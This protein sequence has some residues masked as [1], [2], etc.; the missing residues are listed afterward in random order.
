MSSMRSLVRG[1]L[2]LG[3]LG[4]ALLGQAAL[5]A[6]STPRINSPAHGTRFVDAQY[7]NLSFTFWRQRTRSITWRL[8]DN[9][10]QFCTGSV[11]WDLTTNEVN[12]SCTAYLE[13]GSHT[14]TVS[15]CSDG[16]SSSAVTVNVVRSPLAP[17]FT[18]LNGSYPE[19]ASVAAGMQFYAFAGEPLSF[20]LTEGNVSICSGTINAATS[21]YQSQ[22]CSRVFPPGPH[23]LTVTAC[24]TNHALCKSTSATFNVTRLGWTRFVGAP[25]E[26]TQLEDLMTDPA[27]RSYSTGFT[28]GALDGNTRTGVYDM[29]VFAY[30]WAGGKIWSSQLGAPGTI[31][32]GYG[33]GR[34][35]NFEQLYVGGYTE[36]GLDGNARV[37]TKDAFIS[38]YRYTGVRH[39]TRQL[40]VPGKATEGYGIAVD[41]W[42]NAFVVGSTN[43]VLYGPAVAGRYDA[44]AA[45][46]DGT[47]NLLWT[48]Q[49]GAA[50]ADTVARRAAVDS[51]GNV[52]VAGWTT[53]GLDGNTRQGNQD[54]FVIKYDPSGSKLWTR[55][56]GGPGAGAWL[57]GVA[58]DA[59]GNVYLAGYVGGGL[60]GLPDSASEIDAF[61]SKLDPAGNKLWTRQFGSGSRT[62]AEDVVVNDRGVFVTGSGYGD[63]TNP[64]STGAAPHTYIAKFDVNGNR[65]N[66]LQQQPAT[67][68][69]VQKSV[70]ANAFGTDD[71]G[72]FYVGGNVAGNYDGQTLSGTED[73]FV[74]RLPS[75]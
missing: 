49:L 24:H 5:A 69:G 60:E 39:W 20:S 14:L 37:G 25:G 3:V 70:S 41:P 64:T 23:T 71:N 19:G 26:F 50:G 6:P 27:G 67:L 38:K 31:T 13:P 43:G 52:Y 33:I 2:S 72:N 11:G 73:G 7:V 63:V 46:Y 15:V 42:D 75:P 16:C 28:T 30:D 36:G 21:G 1:V 22:S 18:T 32:L 57:Y 74:T 44:F 55:Q 34:N 12:R 56:V 9:G 40:G 48:R 17:S 4:V 66:V 58:S 8:Y 10:N 53:G 45:K 51:F 47:G 68:S 61:V 62:W 54:V 35:W 65:L 29:F 59:A